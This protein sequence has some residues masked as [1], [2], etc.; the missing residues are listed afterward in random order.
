M[1]DNSTGLLSSDRQARSGNGS[2]GAF[3]SDGLKNGQDF[4][5]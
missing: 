2:V 1:I 3:F 5:R 4:G